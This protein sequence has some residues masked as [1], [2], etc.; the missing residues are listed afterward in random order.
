MK[1]EKT[2]FLTEWRQ[3]A[4]PEQRAALYQY[5]NTS[6]HSLWQVASGRRGIS[7]SKAAEIEAAT[8]AI[9]DADPTLP[10]VLRTSTCEACAE[11]PYAKKC[12]AV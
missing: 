10:P 8:L 3:R 1:A 9:H 11:C 12:G 6:R 5:A 2:I 7:A 4:T